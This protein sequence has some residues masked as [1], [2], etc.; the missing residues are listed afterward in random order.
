MTFVTAGRVGC[1]YK[2]M[3]HFNVMRIGVKLYEVKTGRD[4]ISRFKYVG[5]VEDTITVDRYIRH[6]KVRLARE[7]AQEHGAVFIQWL[8]HNDE[9]PPL[10]ALVAEAE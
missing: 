7:Y 10:Y 1:F 5:A 4:G 3:G 6:K 2:R 8:K 9:V